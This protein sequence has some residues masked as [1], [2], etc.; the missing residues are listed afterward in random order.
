MAVGAG[1]AVWGMNKASELARNLTPGGLADNAARG[2]VGLGDA[3]R[4][5]AGDVREGMVRREL[6][7]NRQLGLD[8]S[9]LAAPGDP[10]RPVLR[11]S[12]T[13]LALETPQ[14][15]PL[16]HH[17]ELDRSTRYEQKEGH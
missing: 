16:T 4:A 17:D 14:P 12:A 9:V 7:L 15:P 11:G 8:G 13:R 10:E 6:E 5:F 3:V 2:A 1:A